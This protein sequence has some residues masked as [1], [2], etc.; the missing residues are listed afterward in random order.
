MA[1]VIEDPAMQEWVRA[2]QNEPWTIESSE[3]G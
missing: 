3:I 1:A 2:A